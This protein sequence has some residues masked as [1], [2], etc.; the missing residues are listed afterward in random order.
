MKSP[1]RL[2][3]TLFSFAFGFPLPAAT[4]LV[5]DTWADGTRDDTNLPEESAWFANNAAGTP[6][7]FV[8][9]DSLIGYVRLFETNTS[10]RL[11]ITHFTSAGSPVVLTPGETLKVTL[12]FQANGVTV[13]PATGRGLRLGL[14]NFSEPGAARVSADGFST[15]AGGGAP[16]ANVTGYLL[17]MNF[18]QAFTVTAPLQIMKR[19]DTANI[20]L[21]G[22]SA[23]YTALSSGGGPSGEPGFRNGAQY[24]FEFSARRLEAATELQ[25][26]F[27][28]DDG[29]SISHSVTDSTNP[30]FTFDSFAIRPNGVADTAEV[31][32]FT[33]FKAETIPYQLRVRSLRFDLIEGVVLT[34]D[35]LPDRTYQVESRSSFDDGTP[36]TL[37]ET[38]AATGLS[39]SYS[40]FLGLF[41]S[42]R[43]YRVVE[44]APAAK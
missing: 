28:D 38:V 1:S 31:F 7:L 22:A 26:T 23:V 11:W 18:A 29:W 2:L 9:P 4:V 16:G 5:D 35:S 3:L 20:N 44:S 41:E 8:L 27:F 10:S 24:T 21:M 30:T 13:S 37:L 42:Q 34:W 36:W 39:T 12:V 15:G 25:T 6:T 43:F 32:T 33:R 19:T 14:F 17:N 40:D